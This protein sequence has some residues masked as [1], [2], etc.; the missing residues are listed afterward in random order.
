MWLFDTRFTKAACLP[1]FAVLITA[2]FA[3]RTEALILKTWNGSGTPAILNDSAPGGGAASEDPG[4]ANAGSTRS[5]IYLG[6]QWVLTA[7][8]VST[9]D[10]VLPSGT[11]SPIPGT[12]VILTNPSM[13]GSKRQSNGTLTSHADLKLFRINTHP[14]SGLTPEQE[15]PNV[16]V[17]EIASTRVTVD[18]EVLMIGAGTHRAI[19]PSDP[20][21]QWHWSTLSPLSGGGG[22]HRQNMATSLKVLLNP[23]V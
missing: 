7:N 10:I 18:T 3:S 23:L 15:D 13:F 16:R 11:Y 5:A 22:R 2:I 12:E 1:L 21:G 20:N 9:G 17:I 19:V 8:H 14:T 6:D 4:W